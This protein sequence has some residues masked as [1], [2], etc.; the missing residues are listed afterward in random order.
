MAE[1]PTTVRFKPGINTGVRHVAERLGVSVNA[2]LS[3]LLSEALE[4]R[5]IDP[6]TGKPIPKE[7]AATS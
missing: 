6:S 1:K 3:V 4:A 5:G 2:A 7:P